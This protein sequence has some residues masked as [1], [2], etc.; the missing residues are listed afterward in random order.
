MKFWC[1]NGGNGKVPKLKVYEIVALPVRGV[2]RLTIKNKHSS[3]IFC[4]FL[5]N[6]KIN[7]KLAMIDIR[8]QRVYIAKYNTVYGLYT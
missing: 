5:N 7:L 1:G 6:L 3:K 2:I 8:K 4:T